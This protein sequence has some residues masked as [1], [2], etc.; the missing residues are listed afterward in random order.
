MTDLGSTAA[1][2]ERRGVGYGLAAYGIWGIVPLFWPLVARAAP[3]EILAQRIVWSLVICGVL[4]LTV[5]PRGWWGRIG[6]RR[7]LTLLALAAALVSVNWGTYIWAVNSGHVVETSL[8]YYIN[9][10]LSILVGVLALRERLAPLQWASIGLAAVAVGVLTLDYGRPPWIALTLATSFAAY[11]VIKKRVD[12]GAVE[13]LTVEGAV[14]TP[15]AL[16]YL[17]Y[18]QAQKAAQKAKF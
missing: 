15:V 17:G 1:D 16:G 9:P 7:S 6:T 18:L 4:I 3:L 8:G 5:V 13:T 14:L 11:G 12:G 10:L 2:R